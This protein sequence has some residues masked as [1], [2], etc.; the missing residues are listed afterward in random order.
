MESKIILASSSPRR[1]QLL[2]SLGLTFEVIVSGYDEN[3]YSLNGYDFAGYCREQAL[4]KGLWIVE[5]GIA[6]PEAS[7]IVSAEPPSVP[8]SVTH[9]P[10]R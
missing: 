3:S 6:T 5:Q 10:F 4:R 8:S 9:M 7:I 1:K 2:E